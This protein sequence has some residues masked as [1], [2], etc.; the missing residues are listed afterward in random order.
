MNLYKLQNRPLITYYCRPAVRLRENTGE[1]GYS[2]GSLESD[3]TVYNEGFTPFAPSYQPEG[4]HH[5][6]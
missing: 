1:S 2:I 4:M 6:P 5:I 3:R